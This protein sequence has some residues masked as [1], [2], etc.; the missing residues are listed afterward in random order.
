MSCSVTVEVPSVTVVRSGT[1]LINGLAGLTVT[2]S[3]VKDR[4]DV[5][6]R[7][8]KAYLESWTYVSNPAN[9]ASVPMPNI[10]WVPLINETAS[11][12]S[13]TSGFI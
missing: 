4:P 12:A 6:N 2:R 13:R 7:L 1:V 10:A 9:K 11:L 5:I 3:F 8:L